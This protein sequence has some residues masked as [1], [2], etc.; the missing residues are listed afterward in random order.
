MARNNLQVCDQNIN[1]FTLSK[2]HISQDNQ[3]L[4]ES[5]SRS[6]KMWEIFKFLLS[7]RGKTFFPEDILEKIWPEN[8]YIAWLELNPEALNLTSQQFRRV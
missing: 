2:F 5:S 8:D 3:V 6:K 7:N 1:I 4:T